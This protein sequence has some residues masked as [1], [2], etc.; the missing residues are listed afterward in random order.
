MVG[1]SAHF[2]AL[3]ASLGWTL[4]LQILVNSHYIGICKSMPISFI[5][6]SSLANPIEFVSFPRWRTGSGAFV[7]FNG[8]RTANTAAFD[9]FDITGLGGSNGFFHIEIYF[10]HNGGGQHG[11]FCRFI[12]TLNAYDGSQDGD[13]VVIERVNTNWGG[14]TGFV[15]TRPS[16]D[17]IRVR[18]A[19]ATS[20]ADA[21]S[22]YGCVRANRIGVNMT[23]INM[24][25]FSVN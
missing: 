8:S 13:N 7:Y 6:Q 4:P 23:N 21:Y 25:S 24:A 16:N 9:M 20:F 3:R 14:G 18:W 19:G 10:G 11:S 12:R 1:K 2:F 5:D 22:L 17:V 15:F